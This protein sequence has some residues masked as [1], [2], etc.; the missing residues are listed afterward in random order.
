M[1][2]PLQNKWSKEKL[3]IIL[4]DK[5]ISLEILLKET[6]NTITLLPKNLEYLRP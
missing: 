5:V 1:T 3:H 4:W 6:L 2:P